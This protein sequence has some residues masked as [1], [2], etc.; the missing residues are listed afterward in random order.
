MNCL[1]G[2]PTIYGVMVESGSLELKAHKAVV[3]DCEFRNN[4]T[5]YLTNK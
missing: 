1:Y 3:C 5:I 4:S 2:K